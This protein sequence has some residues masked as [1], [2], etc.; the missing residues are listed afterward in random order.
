MVDYERDYETLVYGKGAPF[1]AELRD[2]LGPARFET[3]LR[4]YLER[5]RWRIATPAEFQALAEEVA[6]KKLDGMF[7][8]WVY[9]K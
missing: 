6:G 9:G 7:G 3:L 4:T 2:A 5:Y 8:E 1:F